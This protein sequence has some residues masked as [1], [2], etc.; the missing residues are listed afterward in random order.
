MHEAH[1]IITASTVVG[2][3]PDG[4]P[5]HRWTEMSETGPRHFEDRVVTFINKTINPWAPHLVTN[6]NVFEIA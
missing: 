2:T 1:T 4:S 5:M 3:A 6:V